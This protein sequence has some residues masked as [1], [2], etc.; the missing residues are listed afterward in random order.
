MKYEFS[1]D[2]IVQLK[3]NADFTVIFDSYN[4]RYKTNSKYIDFLCPFHGDVHFGSAKVDLYKKKCT[5][6]RCSESFSP[7]DFI[8]KMENLTLHDALIRLADLEGVLYEYE[9]KEKSDVISS[10]PLPR[11][12]AFQK[13]LLGFHETDIKNIEYI[14]SV[15]I[16]KSVYDSKLKK[17]LIQNNTTLSWNYLYTFYPLEYKAIVLDRCNEVIDELN[18]KITNTEIFIEQYSGISKWYFEEVEAL[19]QEKRHEIE[20]IKILFEKGRR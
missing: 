6:F 7:L 19:L 20:K 17:Y 14:T 10:N 8:M 13:E 15:N 1:D 2:D 5:C 3:E 16:P 11:L 18:K 9:S 4:I 12:N